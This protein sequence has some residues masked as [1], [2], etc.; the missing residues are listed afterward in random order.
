[1]TELW[2]GTYP[3]AGAGTP[4]GQGEGVW[5]V[6]LDDETGALTGARL[7]AELPAPSFLALRTPFAGAPDRPGD[8]AGD[9][10][11]P[12]PSHVY[13][14]LE[15]DA[16]RVAGLLP[17]D[18]TLAP[19]AFVPSGGAYPCHVLATEDALLVANYGSGT[20]GVLA[21]DGSGALRSEQPAVLGHAGS[22]PREDRQ[23]GP[24]AHFVA[25]APGGRHVLVVDLGTDEIRR[26]AWDGRTATPD[27][28]AAT[29]PPGTG[30]RHLDFSSDGRF[31]YVAGELDVAVH[32]LAWDTTTATGT[33][34]QSVPAV[35]V[36]DPDEHD[37]DEH[38]HDERGHDERAPGQPSHLVVDS[39]AVLVA[40][41]GTDV[42]TAYRVG[43]DG[44]LGAGRSVDLGGSWPRHFAVVGRWVVVAL[45]RAG[46]LVVLDRVLLT[47]DEDATGSGAPDPV[48]GR[49]PLPSPTCVLPHA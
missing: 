15:D 22:G 46:E 13:A 43:P 2:I 39:G 18:G 1:M 26:Y 31:A 19:D 12:V 41:R 9:D 44:L 24:H 38:G 40:V 11:G 20:L 30:P 3:A 36:D 10:V 17:H 33:P 37:P 28:I 16:G 25:L 47:A 32:V 14:V 27:G 8:G 35:V 7:R 6:V 4:V 23:E 5:S 49:V 42:L 45:E 48:R 34:V 29:L 21:L